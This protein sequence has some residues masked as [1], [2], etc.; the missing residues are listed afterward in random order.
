MTITLK[1]ILSFSVLYLFGCGMKPPPRTAFNTECVVA[2]AAFSAVAFGRV[3][4]LCSAL[5]T[6]S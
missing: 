3:L 6:F 1:N 2:V 5:G 4:E